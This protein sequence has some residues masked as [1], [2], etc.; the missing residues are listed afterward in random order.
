MHADQKPGDL[1]TLFSMLTIAIACLG[2][3]GLASF[4]TEQSTKEIGVR[5]VLGAS[6]PELLLLISKEF[7][8]LAGVVPAVASPITYFTMSRW[9]Q[10]FHY[11]ID[12]EPLIF[13]MAAGLALFIQQIIKSPFTFYVRVW[14]VE[15]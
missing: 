1:F 5:K 3:G 2:L 14:S 12:V 7:I 11:R 8:G 9:L 13:P 4:V 15:S 10:D 6:I